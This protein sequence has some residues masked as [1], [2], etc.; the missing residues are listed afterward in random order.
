VGGKS[1]TEN[2][3][4]S[5]KVLFL[6][7]G[8]VSIFSLIDGVVTPTAG[9]RIDFGW[10]ASGLIL[11]AIYYLAL[12]YLIIKKLLVALRKASWKSTGIQLIL[13][14]AF[15]TLF[16]TAVNSLILPFF[17][18]SVPSAVDNLGF[19]I[20]LIFIFFSFYYHRLLNI[21]LF[22]VHVIVS[23]LWICL[24][25]R[26]LFSQSRYELLFES[27]IFFLSII[28]GIILIRNVTQTI[29]LRDEVALLSS[30]L[31]KAYDRINE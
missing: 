20:F 6:V 26:L 31:K 13:C 15:I 11:Y 10:F 30:N 28:V 8:L 19:L 27:V 21:K 17:L 2:K 22:A 9:S 12:S 29:Y 4:K 5:S 3:L 25:T 16:T 7:T 18:V 24:V 23:L 14:G 1:I